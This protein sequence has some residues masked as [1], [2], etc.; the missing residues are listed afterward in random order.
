M[1]R[2]F[3]VDLRKRTAR[4]IWKIPEQEEKELDGTWST[5]WMWTELSVREGRAVGDKE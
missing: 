1:G 5:D 2:F 4:G 3:I